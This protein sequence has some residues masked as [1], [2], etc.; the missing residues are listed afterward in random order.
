MKEENA[1]TLMFLF[2]SRVIFGD[3]QDKDM[4]LIWPIRGELTALFYEMITCCPP[5][6]YTRLPVNVI[7]KTL[8]SVK[9]G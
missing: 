1:N 6:L 2:E 3:L 9:P 4:R 5:I 8:L 7:S